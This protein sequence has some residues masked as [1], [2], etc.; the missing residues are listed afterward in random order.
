[1]LG[2][3]SSSAD[4]SPRC[5]GSLCADIVIL[6]DPKH[7]GPGFWPERVCLIGHQ[8]QCLGAA[9]PVRSILDDPG[10]HHGRLFVIVAKVK[11]VADAIIMTDKPAGT[12][13]KFI[14]VST[15]PCPAL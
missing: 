5:F 4:L 1:M 11:N 12:E 8:T 9:A 3:A 7:P 6:R 15:R 10:A 13:R 2:L 14:A